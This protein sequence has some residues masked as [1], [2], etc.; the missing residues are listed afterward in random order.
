[1]AQN[2][3]PSVG[4]LLKIPLARL[5]LKVGQERGKGYGGDDQTLGYATDY[6][7]ENYFAAA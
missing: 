7:Q 4:R 6:Y 5:L 2:T 1:M 3:P